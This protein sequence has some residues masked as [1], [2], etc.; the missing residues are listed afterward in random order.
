MCL[1]FRLGALVG[2]NFW[3]PLV[4]DLSVGDLGFGTD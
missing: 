2:L 1:R 4:G 3:I